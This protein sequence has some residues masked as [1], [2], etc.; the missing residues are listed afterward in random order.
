MVRRTTRPSALSLKVVYNLFINKEGITI[1]DLAKNIRTDYKNVHD[2]VTALFEDGIIKKEKIGNYNICRLNYFNEDIVEYLKDY[3]FYVKLGEFRKKYP[4]EYRII[5]ETCEQ[6]KREMPFF[7]CLA[8]GSYA[9]GEERKG[10]DIDVLFLNQ[11]KTSESEKKLKRIN[12]PYQKKFH[13]VT[14]Q[15]SSFIKD[16]KNKKEVSVATELYKQLP[17]VFY[18]DDIF[19]KILIE[20]NK[21]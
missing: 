10:S 19:F 16:L 2:S 15:V 14:Q 3:N 18:G 17:I 6:L 9:K 7:I 20:A 1:K 11:S 5:M 4:I 13:V 12:L 8:F 21:W